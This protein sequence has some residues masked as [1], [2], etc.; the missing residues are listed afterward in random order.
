MK[1]QGVVILTPEH[2]P[3]RLNP[4][5]FGS[6]FMAW[7]IDAI[8]QTAFII[9][10]SRVLG[11]SG[12]LMSLFFQTLVFLVTWSYHVF[13]DLTGQGRTPGKRMMGLRV[14]DERGLPISL[15]QSFVRNIVRVFDMQPGFFYGVGGLISLLH[16]EG[17]RLGDIAAGTL[18]VTETQALNYPGRVAEG[19]QYNSLRNPRVMRAIRHKIRLEEREFL[20]TLCLRAPKMDDKARFDLMDEVG[21][22]Y[23]ERLKI[24]DE[25]LSGENLV[26]GITAII[27]E[28]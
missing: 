4:A 27:F 21:S 1:E 14:V 28:K 26:R 22:Y 23:R 3:I 17:R 10:L 13:F 15:Q 8:F 16:P 12:T 6:R 20:L 9:F 19:R 7:L 11:A 18:V 2:V 5:G 24:E 25:H